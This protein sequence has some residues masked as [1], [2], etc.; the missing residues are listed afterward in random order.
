MYKISK[1][2]SFEYAHLLDLPYSSPCCNIHGHSA[3]VNVN[4][5][6]KNINDSGMLIDF[7]ELNFIK[8]YINETYDHKLLVPKSKIH[9]FSNTCNII[10]FEKNP[11]AEELSKAFVQYIKFYIFYEYKYLNIDKIEVEFFETEN[12]SATY[13]EVINHDSNCEDSSILHSIKK[14]NEN[15]EDSNDRIYEMLKIITSNS[16]N[17]KKNKINNYICLEMTD[18]GYIYFISKLRS[19]SKRNLY[20]SDNIKDP[21]FELILFL[22]EEHIL[23]PQNKDIDE[24]VNSINKQYTPSKNNSF[25][26]TTQHILDVIENGYVGFSI[27]SWNSDPSE[28]ID[29]NI[30]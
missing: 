19:Y 11:T 10:E 29:E 3:K 30:N 9:E 25:K 7:K 16:K 12:N 1:Q 27:I 2:F 14:I 23:I 6:S 21:I 17:I 4:I 18:K 26:F 28:S 5:Y 24:I 15:K 13:T 22:N 8:I 20:D